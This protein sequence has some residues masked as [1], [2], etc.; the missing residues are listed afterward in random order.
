[1][2]VR[3]DSMDPE[4]DCFH[5]HARRWRQDPRKRADIQRSPRDHSINI[6]ICHGARSYSDHLVHHR[7]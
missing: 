7:T 3:D 4:R 1:M 5:H 2:K 6:V